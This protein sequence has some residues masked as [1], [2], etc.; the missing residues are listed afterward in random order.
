LAGSGHGVSGGEQIEGIIIMGEVFRQLY[1]HVVWATKNREPQL[2]AALRSTLFDVIRDKCR[3]LVCRLHAVNAM[4]DH[5]HLA[6]EIPPSRSVSFVLGQLKGASSHAVN[7]VRPGSV[8]WQDGYGV[9][10]FRRAELAKV[11]QYVAAQ[12]QRHQSGALSPL[13]ETWEA[14]DEEVE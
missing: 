2:V 6:I 9:V 8:H 11:I 4:D 14:P 1:Y 3:R 10:T 7:Q 12:E 13:L 5:V